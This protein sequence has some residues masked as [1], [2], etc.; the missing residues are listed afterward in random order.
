MPGGRV[1][2]RG[3][4]LRSRGVGVDGQALRS[5]LGDPQ[6]AVRGPDG[7]ADK[8]GGPGPAERARTG[9]DGPGRRAPARARDGAA[10]PE[11]VYD[12]GAWAGR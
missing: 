8:P 2:W 6:G 7:P 3:L 9:G 12:G 5:R 1:D 11:H 4:V 10:G